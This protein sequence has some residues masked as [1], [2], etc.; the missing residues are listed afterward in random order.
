MT[1]TTT[2]GSGDPRPRST[3]FGLSGKLLVLTILF[4]MIAEVLIYVPSMANFRLNWLKDRLASA[5]TAA[6][7]L[8]A[9]PPRGT[10]PEGLTRRILEDVGAK[11][12]AMKIGST[13]RMRASSDPLPPV[14]HDCDMREVSA[15]RAIMDAVGTLLSGRHDLM[16]VVGPAPMGGDF[17]ELVMEEAPLQLAMWRFSRNI[18]VLSL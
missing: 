9:V 1:Q 17:I 4:V 8:D 12:I 14:A 11:A 6:L 15:F 18:L 3:W 2:A 16:R 7:V 5:H 10:V 13:R